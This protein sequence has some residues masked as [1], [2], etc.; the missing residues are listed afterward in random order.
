M[1]INIYGFIGTIVLYTIVTKKPLKVIYFN[2]QLA[3][4]T[5]IG[6]LNS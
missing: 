6:S 3:L 1:S 5:T 2:G 4:L